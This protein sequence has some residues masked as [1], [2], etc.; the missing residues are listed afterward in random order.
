MACCSHLNYVYVSVRR[1]CFAAAHL[2]SVYQNLQNDQYENSEVFTAVLLKIQAFRDVTLRQR[3]FGT[4]YWFHL[5]LRFLDPEDEDP[6]LF[7]NV[8]N[9]LPVGMV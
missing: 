2:T 5:H 9:Y 8:G 6:I 1:R 4:S 3:R 7:R